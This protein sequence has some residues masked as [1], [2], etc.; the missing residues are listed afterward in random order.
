MFRHRWRPAGALVG[1]VVLIAAATIAVVNLARPAP[2]APRFQ[3]LVT[4]HENVLPSPPPLATMAPQAWVPNWESVSGGAYAIPPSYGRTFPSGFGPPHAASIPELGTHSGCDPATSSPDPYG[5]CGW[6]AFV[7]CEDN[8]WTPAC[9]QRL[10]DGSTC[11]FGLRDCIEAQLSCRLPIAGGSTVGGFAIFPKGDVTLDPNSNRVIMT[12]PRPDPLGITYDKAYG[13]WVHT[14][15]ALISPNGSH[16]ARL[17]ANWAVHDVGIADGTDRVVSPTGKWLP[18][19]YTE[20]GIYA[21]PLEPGI[22]ARAGLW[23][24]QQG[25]TD[26]ITKSGYWSIVGGGAAYGHPTRNPIQSPNQLMRLDLNRGTSTLWFRRPGQFIDVIG[27]DGTGNPIVW[28]SGGQLAGVP[29][30]GYREI[31]LVTGQ[32]AGVKL[33]SGDFDFVPASMTD[34]HGTWLW[35]GGLYL[36]TVVTDQAGVPHPV[37]ATIAS[38]QPLGPCL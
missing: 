6:G 7:R 11:G 21:V 38:V 9:N 32:D 13:R 22:G 8:P 16:Y 15:L 34:K 24:F 4:T 35:A 26:G 17:D 20:A 12:G 29:L 33:I 30:P 28:A 36:L 27:F 31:W 37:F 5:P 19:A 2:S 23:L 25:R 14:N 18:I 10:S 1:V 3:D